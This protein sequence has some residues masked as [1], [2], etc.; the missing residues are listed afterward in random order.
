[1]IKYAKSVFI[2]ASA[3]RFAETGVKAVDFSNE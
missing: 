2:A 1:M 3:G